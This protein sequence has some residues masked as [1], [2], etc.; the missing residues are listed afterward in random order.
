M[1]IKFLIDENFPPKLKEAVKRLNANIDI[2]R[3]GNEN[4]PI[5]GTLDPDILSY[6]QLSQRILI[7]DNRNSMPEHLQEYWQKG[8]SI[9]GLLWVR[10][11]QKLRNIAE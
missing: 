7:T 4:A 10:P 5:S 3:V 2:I 9:W 11:R 6:L 8:G 1:K